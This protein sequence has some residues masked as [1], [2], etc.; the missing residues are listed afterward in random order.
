MM[1]AVLAV[2]LVTAVGTAA[3]MWLGAQY[4]LAGKMSVGS[5][6][7]FLS[8]LASLHGPLNS[9]T[10]TASTLQYAA[11]NANRVVEIL[12]TPPDVRDLPEARE[13]RLLGHVRYEDV[14]F[15]YEPDRPAPERRPWSICSCGSSTHGRA[16]SPWMAGT[17]ARSA[18]ARCANRSGSSSRSP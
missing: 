10:Y 9:I 6:L 15:G 8:Y 13:A 17:S 2:G 16:R 7:V 5:V 12:D 18:F 11:A 1:A 14:T 3:I 4:V